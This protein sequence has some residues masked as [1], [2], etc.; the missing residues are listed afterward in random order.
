[1]SDRLGQLTKGKDGKSKYSTLSLFDKYKGK[2]VEAIR[3]TVIPRHGLQSLGKV[4]I[5]R[6]MPPPANLPSLKSENKGNDPNIIIV[7]KDGTG[8]ANKQDQPDQKSS[9][10]TA[11]QPQESLP[12]PGLQKSVS[13]LQKPTQSISQENTNSVPGGLKSWAQ[14]NGKPAGYEGGSRGSSRLLSFS[15]EEF[16]TLK[17]AGEQDKVGKEKGVLDPSYGPGPSLRPQNVTSWREGGG[18]NITSASSLTASPSEP[19]SKNSSTGDG[20]P[21]SA[22]TSDSKEPSLRPAQ[23]TRKGAS[24]FMGN[25][26]HPPTYHDML[27]AFMCT[28]QSSEAQG[29]VERGS[30]PLPQLRLEPRVPFRQYQMNDQDGK[31]T[32]MGLSRPTRP[33]RQQGERAPRP[34]IINAENLRGLDELDTDAD[35]GW[36]GLHDEV[37]YSEKLKFSEDEEEEEALKDGR[38]KWNNWDPRRQRQLSLSSADSADVKHPVEENKN[39]GDAVGLSRA[40]RKVPEPQPPARKPNSWTPAPDYQKPSLGGVLRQQSLEDREE[41]LPPRQKFVQSEI[42]EA[43]ERARRRREEEER[44]ARE[45][46]LAACAAKL[47]QLD[48]KCRQAQKASEAQKQVENEESHPPSAEKPPVQENS[49]PL[50]RA[51]PELHTQETPAAYPEEEPA[52]PPAVAQS[53]SDEELR[54]STSPAQEFSKFQ[55]SLPP[56]FQRQQQQEQLYKMQH[57]QQ[58]QVYPPPSHSH[59]QRTFYPAHP[60]MLGFDPRWM[61]MPSY[62]DPRMTPARTPVDFYPSALHPSGIMK[63]IMAQD[64]IN[65]PGCRSE[66]Q[67]CPPSIQQE[68][69]VAPI[70]PAPVWSQDGYAAMQSKGYSLPHPKQNES[71]TVEGVRGRNESSYSASTGRSGGVSAQ[72]DLFEERGDEYLNAFDKKAPADFDS[73]VPSQ[74]IGQE[75]LFPPQENVQEAG[76][77]GGQHSSLRSS[78]LESDL[79]PADKKSEYSG[80]DVG[81]TPKPSDP[82]TTVRE[83]APRDE[84]PFDSDPWKKEGGATK[85]PAPESEWTPENRTTSTPHQEQMGRS[86]RSGPIKKPVLKALKVEEK[87]KELEKIKLEGGEESTRPLKEKGSPYKAENEEGDGEDPKSAS[88]AH[89]LLDEKDPSQAGFVREAEKFEEEEKAERV[90]ETKLSKDSS[91]LPPTKRNNWIF[92]DEEQA[93]G[94]GQNRGRGRGFREFTFRGRGTGGSSGIGSP[95]GVYISQRSSRGRGLRE[96]NQIDDFPRGK[97]RRRIASE[98]HSEGSEY[99]ELPKRRRQRGLETGNEGSLLEREESDLKKGDFKDSWR[100][101]KIYSDDYSSLDAKNRGPR[102]FGRALPPRLSNSGYGRRSFVTK[103][104][105]HWQSRSGGAPWQDYG[106]GIPSDSFGA[107]RAADRDYSQESYK[108]SDSFIGR[109]FE[110]SHLDDKRSFFQDDYAADPENIEN[111]PFRRR[112]PPRQDKPPRFRRLRQERESLGQWGSEE[113]PN[114]LSGQWPGRPKLA[115][116]EKSSTTG[117]RSPELSYQNSSDHANEEWETASESSDFSER[118]ERREGG[119]AE[120][121]AQLDGGLAGAN[122]GEK[123]EL[124]KRSFSSQRPL[125]DRQSRKMEP[126]G[127]GEKSVR[128]GGGGAVTRYESQ[129]NG[130]PLKTKR[131]PEETLPGSLSSTNGGSGHSSYSLERA[132]HA[133]SSDTTEAAGKKPEKDPQ[134][135][136]QRAGEKG[137]AMPQ[138]DL[139]YGNAI[140]DNRVSS[141]G[142]ESEVGPIVSEGFIEVLTKKQRRLLEEERRKKEQAV[143]VPAKGRGLSSRIPPR[144]AKKQ[145]TMCLEQGDVTVSGSSLGTEI[146][147]SNSQALPV[148]SPGSDSWS[149]AVNAFNSTESSSTEGFKGSQGDSGID[150]SAE[151]R[152]SSATSSQRSSPYGTLKPEEMNGAG[153]VEPKPDCQKEQA[154]KQ[155]DK[156]DSEQGS[157][158]SKEHKPGPIGNERSLKNRKGSE[159]AERLEG[160]VPPVNGVEIHVDSVLPVPPIE[161]GVNP[162]ENLRCGNAGRGMDSQYPVCN[163]EMSSPSAEHRDSDFSLPPGSASGTSAN[164]VAK[165]QDALASNAGLAQSIP[166]LRRDHHLPRGISLNP[167]SFPTADLTLKMESARKAWENSPNLPE[168]SSPGGAG[169]GIQPPSSVGASNGVNYSSFGG[170]SMPPMPVASVA[171]S[172]SIPGN[173]IPPLYLDGHV[174]ASQPRLVPQTIP[175]QQSYQQAAAAQQIPISLHTS[176][177]AQAQLGLRGGLPVSQSQEIYS[178][179]PPFRSQ[180]YMH[181]S[182]SQPNTMVLAGG[183]ALKPP[184]SAFPGMQPLEMVKT[185][186]GSPYQPMNGSQALVYEGQIG[187]AAGMGASQMMDS[188]LTQ[189]TMPLPGS[190]LPLPRYGSGQQPLILPQSIQLPQGQNL[191]V[192]APRRILPPGSQPSVLAT[193]R[194]S[195]QMEMK[196]FHFTDGKQSIPSGGS[197]PSPQTYRPSSASPSGKP[198]GPAVNMGSVQGHYVQQA[199]QRVDENK[200][201]LGAVKLQE[202]PPATQMKRT[203]AIKPQAVK[204]EESK[205]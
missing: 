133:T 144:F 109:G 81:Q 147:E 117:R 79:V 104:S 60:Q 70:D 180:V 27:P 160:N 85:Q 128:T 110:E 200:S 154:Q 56:R 159:G 198:S 203:G 51:T 100:S 58:Q 63:P 185:Q 90:W 13:N 17:A 126:G 53:S 124:A 86:R 84:Q 59:P 125:V 140:I 15:P 47:K 39:W 24:Q 150:L 55:K 179:I 113:G 136:I 155:S 106:S 195:S 194:E 62:M 186:S 121:D 151:S 148:Q 130:T 139:S 76:G 94:R 66:E 4:A 74:R 168:Q 16:P 91:D 103:E 115:P 101:N 18:R 173:H 23:P 114:S 50:R 30:F 36:A 12:Q 161:F 118:R 54:E 107:R 199:K 46:R 132:A 22:C 14:L 97:P 157:G 48:Q 38:Q 135:A 158:Q 201:S 153:L 169:S 33:V 170:V 166:I 193:S 197:V 21:S 102:A 116:G 9:S 37:D 89:S 175:Q 120:G 122:L 92:I 192:G 32:R 26:Y 143:Q 119:A 64:S 165:L 25:V 78:P 174:F 80:W 95:R 52:V 65:G 182:L 34:T 184:Y 167:M 98:T 149:K 73:C 189:L 8:W 69:K 105:P 164:P 177:Q 19:G 205:A 29:T 123:R 152:E 72:R 162:K 1:M 96:F 129:P 93:F 183:T 142:E 5:A 141:P 7:P 99:E 138:F 171:P 2:S 108:H 146:W 6:R 3:T 67:N 44:R 202:P 111:R 49:H 156:K 163:W 181:P 87:E 190:Q 75:L 88:S 112:R 172:A 145:G 187:Q 10:V 68:R 31:E 28:Q 71:L 45:E 131:S 188:Q 82:A 77:P 178:S 61:M 191:S 137:E 83:E 41:K 127:F 11:S 40:I 57:W 134:V 204:A 42:S 20:A 35:D 196:G 43:V 176:L